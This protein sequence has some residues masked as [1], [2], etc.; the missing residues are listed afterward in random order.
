MKNNDHGF[1][2]INNSSIDII[3]HIDSDYPK[4]FSPNVV[5][6][7]LFFCFFLQAKAGGTYLFHFIITFLPLILYLFTKLLLYKFSAWLFGEEEALEEYLFQTTLFNKYLGVVYLILT[8]LLIYS[9]VKIEVLYYSGL[10]MLAL[11]LLFQLVRGFIIGIE[12]G[13]NLLFI[14]LYLCTLE[15]TPWLILGKWIKFNL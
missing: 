14:I 5:L 9:S 3:L 8:T 6:V 11:F 1:T 7:P 2:K 12:R 4:Q 10:I 13:S 15:I